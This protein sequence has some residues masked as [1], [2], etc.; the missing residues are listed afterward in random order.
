MEEQFKC[1]ICR[2]FFKSPFRMTPCGH[3]FCQ[4]CLTGMT[5]IP[6]ECPVCRTEQ[7]QRP[8]ELARNF[9]LETAFDAFMTS[10]KNICET[11]DMPKKLRKQATFENRT[12]ITVLAPSSH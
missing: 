4:E 1:P 2:D 10:R 8:Q 3:T 12:K 5:A 11:H 6:W 7:Q 9:G